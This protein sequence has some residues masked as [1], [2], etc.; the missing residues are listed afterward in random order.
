MTA[1]APNVTVAKLYECTSKNGNVY[2][3]GRWGMASVVMLKSKEVSDTGQPIWYLKLQEAPD[4]AEQRPAAA[5]SVDP[6]A[7]EAAAARDW[8]RPEGDDRIPF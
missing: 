4:K 6:A 2:M 7:S 8:Q 5:L 1:Y 3:R